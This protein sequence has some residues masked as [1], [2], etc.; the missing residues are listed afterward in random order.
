MTVFLSSPCLKTI[1]VGIDMMLNLIA[2]CWFSSMFILTTLS[3]SARSPA[4]SSTTGE[5][6]RQGP[7]QGAQKSTSTGSS[8]SSTSASKLLSVTSVTSPGISFSLLATSESIAFRSSYHYKGNGRAD[9]QR[10]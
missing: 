9:E 3:T 5:T 4:L 7:H 6:R 8:D 2:V 10:N 1:N